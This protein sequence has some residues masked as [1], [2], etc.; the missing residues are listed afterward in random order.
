VTRGL[1]RTERER[2]REGDCSGFR[3]ERRTL[4]YHCNPWNAVSLMLS[5]NLITNSEFDRSHIKNMWQVSC[6]WKWGSEAHIFP[7]VEHIHSISFEVEK[8][9]VCERAVAEG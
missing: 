6:K 1:G 8:R 7:S 4:P 5:G 9:I 2:E 3:L